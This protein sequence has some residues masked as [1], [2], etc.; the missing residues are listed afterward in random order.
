MVNF[1]VGSSQ[2][3]FFPFCESICRVAIRAAQITPRQA[4]EDARQTREGAF[5]LQAQV[6]FVDN[7]C[8]AHTPNFVET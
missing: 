2:R 8:L 5:A 7:Q 1:R 4:D 6:Y 3:H